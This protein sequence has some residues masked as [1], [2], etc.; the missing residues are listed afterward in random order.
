[1]IQ[2]SEITGKYYETKEAVYY[3][4]ILQSAFMISKPDMILLDLFSDSNG[5]L[6]FFFPRELH[7]KY[8]QEWHNRPHEVTEPKEWRKKMADNNG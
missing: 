1:M 3:R 2:Y 8:I 4:N 5:M 7:K 6:V